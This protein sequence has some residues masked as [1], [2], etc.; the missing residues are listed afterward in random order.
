MENR[1]VDLRNF[2]KVGEKHCESKCN[3]QVILTKE[4]AVI[5]CNGC[6]RI[7]IDKR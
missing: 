5:V 3:R 1:E 7:L 4:G 2:A 6:N